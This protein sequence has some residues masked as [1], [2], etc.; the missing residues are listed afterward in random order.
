MR[1]LV[2]FMLLWSYGFSKPII[3]VVPKTLDANV[4]SIFKKRIA[5]SN[6]KMSI[7]TV[8]N[9]QK[10][11]EDLIMDSKVKFAMVRK[12][13]LWQLQQ[14]NKGLWKNKYITI[15]L[16][17]YKAKL[18]LIQNKKNFDLDI[19]LLSEKNISIGEIG[20]GNSYYLKEMLSLFGMKHNI[21]YKSY[22]Y[23]KSIKA[24]Q[25]ESI[26]AYFGF[27]PISIEPDRL[28]YQTLFSE[29]T[30]EYF[31]MKDIFKI[32]YNGI[33]SSYVLI[34]SLEAN[35]E[36]IENVIYRLMEKEIF[37]PEIGE[38]FGQINRYVLNHLEEVKTSLTKHNL[39][40]KQTSTSGVK[41]KKC[42]KYHYGFLKLLRQKPNLKKKLKRLE[43]TSKRKRY[44]KEMDA[45]LIYIDKHKKRCSL[46]VLNNQ[47]RK[48]KKLK[49]KINSIR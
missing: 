28:H 47:K 29:S 40:K 37:A 36:E 38:R 11:L 21:S 10:A 14:E 25:D 17:P 15:S 46:E 42:R 45:I 2:L 12:D 39:K 32:D 43:D 4:K 16:L 9:N 44:L 23:Q 48:F 22:S 7:K 18:Y 6:L 3:C 33:F 13:I 30:I 34:A 26:N 35:D 24:L 5:Y 19:D 20:E 49:Q 27:L 41:S 1:Y 8:D 31:K